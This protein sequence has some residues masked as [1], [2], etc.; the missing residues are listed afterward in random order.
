MARKKPHHPPEPGAWTRP[1]T[2]KPRFVHGERAVAGFGDRWFFVAAIPRAAACRIIVERH[3]SGRFVNN[4]YVHLGVFID[5]ALAGVLQFGYAMTPALM[6]KVVA[7]TG[8]ADYLELNRMWLDDAAPR[9]SESR[10]IGY[11]IRYIRAAMPHVR[12]IQSYADERCGRL[13]VVYQAANFLF[14]GSHLTDFYE[15]DGVTYHKM[16]LTAHRKAGQRGAY[17]RANV[18]RAH[19][20]RLRQYRYIRFL[21]PGARRHLRFTVKPYPKPAGE[22]PVIRDAPATSWRELGSMPGGRSNPSDDG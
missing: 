4:S 2:D 17:L 9:N 1:W 22:R 13:G 18:D 21:H 3:Y 10:A 7:G 5:G 15:L 11:A 6:G 8:S 19:R 14:V 16:L 12:W 20:M